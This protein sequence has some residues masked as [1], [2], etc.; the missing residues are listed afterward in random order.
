[1]NRIEIK[2]EL[3]K[4]ARE[5]SFLSVEDLEKKFPKYAL[6]EKGE[7]HPT[8]K[9]LEDLA[10]KTLTPLGYFFL[11]APPDDSLPIPDFRT[12]DDAHVK[13]PSPNLLETVQAMQRRQNWMRDYLIEQGCEKLPFVGAS[14]LS[15]KP[16]EVACDIRKVLSRD[17]GWAEKHNT[18][19]EALRS[20]RDT[21][22]DAGIMIVINGV[23]GNSTN[24][25]LDTEEFRGFILV[26]DYAPLVFVNDTDAKGA[27]MFTIAHELAH[28]W[29]GETGVFNLNALQPSNNEVEKF[30]NKVAAEFLIPE[31][32]INKSW[33]EAESTGAPFQALARQFK[34]SPI[35][36]ARRA[37]D[38]NLIDRDAFFAFYAKYQEDERRKKAKAGGGGD[39]Y[40]TQN[41]RIGVHFGLSV[42]R[43]A[44]EGHLQYH[45]A[46]QLTGLSGETFD[47]YAMSLCA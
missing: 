42:I 22:D 32:E 3:F 41:N 46:Y 25:K 38:V 17:P 23:V 18:W 26:D 7:E 24:R 12:V 16:K 11:P 2:P 45:D 15:D 34:V 13:R 47:R 4:W 27:Q 39:F 10:K 9:Q 44:K 21:V 6:W 1:M 33:A 5:R 30:C 37:L 29:L 14:T 28:L 35:V 19:E 40:L 36:A 8:L 20:L 43:A 31:E